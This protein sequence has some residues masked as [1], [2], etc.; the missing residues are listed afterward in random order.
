MLINTH[1]S[2]R[3][4]SHA[5]EQAYMIRGYAWGKGEETLFFFQPVVRHFFDL[6]SMRTYLG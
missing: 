6:I 3:Y 2:T 4:K 5:F 1:I